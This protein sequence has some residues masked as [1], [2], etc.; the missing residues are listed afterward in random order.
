M[1]YVPAIWCQVEVVF[2]PKPGKNSYTGPRD[3]RPISLTSFMLKTLER[4]VDRYIRD[5]TLVI[6]PLHPNQHAYQVGKSVETALHQLV[7]RVEK[8]LDQQELALGVFLDIEGAYN[9]TSFDSVCTALCGR[10]V[11][12]TIVRW[13]RATLEG[14]LAMAA[15]N[16]VCVWVA[17]ARG[18]LQGGVL[19]P[20]LWCLVVD[21]LIARLNTGGVYCQGYA[22]DIC[23][24]AGRK[25]PNMVSELMQGALYTAEKWCDKVGLSV[26]P[27]KT[28]LV[29][30][31]KKRKLDSFFEPLLFGVTLHHSESVRYL[32][33]TLDS[34]LNWQEYVNKKVMKAQN[35]LWA[36]RRSFG[37]VWGLR[38][39]VVY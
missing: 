8:V 20:L 19:S 33:V 11:D 10:G 39:R 29:V 28:D 14:R 23:L 4:L 1:G 36:C 15:L 16:D 35:S 38:P 12:S 5:R 17:V 32:G 9:Y 2:I 7:V 34:R 31:T 13:I 22:D 27:D 3:F 18:C 24:L 26:N 25:F 21:N 6:K 37:M 30:F